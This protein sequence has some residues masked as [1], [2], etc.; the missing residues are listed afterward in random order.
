DQDRADH[1]GRDTALFAVLGGVL[2]Q[3]QTVRRA[4][5][6]HSPSLHIRRRVTGIHSTDVRAEW[7]GIAMRIHFFVVKVVVPLH[8]RAERRVVFVWR[9][10]ERRA[11]A[12]AA[13]EL[14]GNEFLL[15]RCL[16]MLAYKFTE[17]THMLL[18]PTI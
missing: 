15:L 9:Q 10:H 8:I 2:R 11:A 18:K 14:G 4:A 3:M 7:H 12:P 13:H 16:T 17:S 1:Q 5:A 6:D